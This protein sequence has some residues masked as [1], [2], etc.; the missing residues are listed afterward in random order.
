MYFQPEKAWL[1]MYNSIIYKATNKINQK[2]Y[3]GKTTHG[4]EK[5]RK[6]HEDNSLNSKL[7]NY[8]YKAM[9]K[10]G[11]DSFKWEIIDRANTEKELNILEQFYI[12][13]YKE[14]GQVYNLTNGGDGISGFVF[15]EESKRKMSKAHKGKKQ[16]KESKRK[17][18]E[19]GKGNKHNLGRKASKETKRKMSESGKGNKNGLGFKHTEE[20][21]RKISEAGKGLPSWNKGIPCSKEHREKLSEANK[22]K[23]HTEEARK[24]MREAQRIR[25]ER[26][27]CYV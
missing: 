8:F 7:N 25:R 19:A 22:G 21:K 16:T 2:V 12:A 9:R 1:C 17:L 4:L 6:R 26:E 10:H 5:R 23:H 11:F 15:S 20:A 27:G 3:I 13:D 18:S 24:N 14:K